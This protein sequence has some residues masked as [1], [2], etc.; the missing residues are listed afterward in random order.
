[1]QRRFLPNQQHSSSYIM[2]TLP[3]R[4]LCF[5]DW[6]KCLQHLHSRI[7][8]CRGQQYFVLRVF[9]RCVRRERIM[10]IAHLK[11]LQPK[12]AI[13]DDLQCAE[14]LMIVCLLTHTCF[15]AAII[16]KASKMAHFVLSVIKKII[17]LSTL[18]H[19]CV[20]GTET[21]SV[22]PPLPLFPPIYHCFPPSTILHFTHK[23][24]DMHRQP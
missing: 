10:F 21:H 13:T 14:S 12:T 22:S 9:C 20:K 6:S 18:I 16:F 5:C 15:H 3:G 24:I 19:M 4:I 7:V 11:P 1:M 23:H 2:Q 8:C 17:S